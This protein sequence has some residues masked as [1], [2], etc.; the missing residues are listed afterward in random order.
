MMSQC[1]ALIPDVFTRSVSEIAK[2]YE[3][4]LECSTFSLMLFLY[5]QYALSLAA[6]RILYGVFAPLLLEES[7]RGA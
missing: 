6:Q 4:T 1:L 2:G 3:A 5:L 7:P